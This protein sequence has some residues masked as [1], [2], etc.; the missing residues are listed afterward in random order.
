MTVSADRTIDNF[1]DTGR[2]IPAS[3]IEPQA[4]AGATLEK[5]T[6]PTASGTASL[7]KPALA[8]AHIFAYTTADGSWPGAN[9]PNPLEGTDYS[10]VLNDPLT[11]VAKLTELAAAD[12]SAETWAVLYIPLEASAEQGGNSSVTP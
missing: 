9:P 11:G 3:A 10:V 7:S 5:V 12:R 2:K 1:G 4:L 8:I 6:G